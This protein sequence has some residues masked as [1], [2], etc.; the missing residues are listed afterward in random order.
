MNN[1]VYEYF[2]TNDLP[3]YIENASIRYLLDFELMLSDKRRRMRGGYDDPRFL[4]R[5]ETVKVF[6]DL[7]TG[8]RRLTLYEIATPAVE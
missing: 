7:E 5:I 3:S 1:D 6:D 2:S 8:W 4:E